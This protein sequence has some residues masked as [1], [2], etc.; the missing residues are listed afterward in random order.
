VK[1]VILFLIIS[2]CLFV[3]IYPKVA[4]HFAKTVSA[5]ELPPNISQSINQF[6]SQAQKRNIN[7]SKLDQIQYK[8]I[9]DPLNLISYVGMCQSHK[10]GSLEISIV[11]QNSINS[12]IA[13]RI[14][15]HE[16]GH[17][18]LGY[19][20]FYDKKNQSQ[21]MY[22]M[23]NNYDDK[24]ITE[25]DWDHFFNDSKTV[26]PGNEALDMFLAHLKSALFLI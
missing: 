23:K 4:P 1:K 20:H 17:C 14:I 24:E 9:S 25:L 2:L 16:L 7:Y 10:D 6:R 11:N 18:V 13:D 21:I 3:I 8:L 15:I 12:I 19:K 26:Y 5:K 22:F